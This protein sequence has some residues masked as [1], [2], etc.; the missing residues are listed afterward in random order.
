L[1]LIAEKIT[2]VP[3]Q[4]R[5]AA[6]RALHRKVAEKDWVRSAHGDVTDQLGPVR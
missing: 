2:P 5:A 3:A 6:L 4:R 1:R